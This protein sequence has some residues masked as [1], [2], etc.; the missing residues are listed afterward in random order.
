M[1]YT[2][3]LNPCIDVSYKL[4]EL[5]PGTTWLDV[6]SEMIPAGKGL[7]V[8]RAIRS[9]GEEVCVVGAMPEND[10]RR[11]LSC[12]EGL[13]I[14]TAFCPVEGSARINT[15]ILEKE[16]GGATHIN[17]IGPELSPRI[18]ED[19]ISLLVKKVH[20]G[21]VV[22]FSGSVPRGLDNDL[23]KKMIGEC[24]QKKAIT[25]LDSRGKALKFGM[26]AKPTMAKPN[27]S[28]LEQYFGEQIQGVQ[29]IALKAKKLLDNGIGYVF[30]SLGSDGMIALHE[31]DCL[32]C[33]APQVKVA[34]TVGSG[35]ATVAGLVVGFRR[36]FSFSEMC[37]MAVACGASNA[38]HAGPGNIV[39][40]EVAQL[41]EEVE[42]ENA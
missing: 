21:D 20:A 8:A 16:R 5:Q 22:V 30:V 33:S 4:D 34:D 12:C 6:P 15:T 41:M 7:N 40:D 37:R 35:D 31:N 14:G 2:V 28:E 32:L 38:M 11:F 29:H 3:L 25:V 1:I 18:Q 19:I 39:G 13:G 42:I 10:E 27:L 9:L 26:R 17:S 24:R 23:Y 36:Q